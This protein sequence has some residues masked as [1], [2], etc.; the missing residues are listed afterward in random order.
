MEDLD[1]SFAHPP[2]REA[3]DI[4]TASE[5]YTR[6]FAGRVGARFLEI[7]RT[8][9][10]TM[11]SALPAGSTVCDVGG[12]H[13]QVAPALADRGFRVTVTGSEASCARG[14]PRGTSF[15]FAASSLY[16]L[17]FPDGAFD[18]ALSIRVIGHLE[19]WPAFVGEL[20]RIAKRSVVLDFAS[21]RSLNYFATS[22]F[23][24][25]RR[26][27]GDTRTFTV[28]DPS[29]LRDVFAA[30]GFRIA[31]ERPQYVLPM[32]VYRLLGSVRLLEAVE[33]PAARLGLTARFGSP[34]L[35][36]A[37]RLA[38]AGVAAAARQALPPE[39][40]AAVRRAASSSY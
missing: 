16:E 23:G 24:L 14:L 37:D 32:A 5:A 29:R 17:P 31:A 4:E 38:E 26:I 1:E 8:H 15:R 18:V 33:R 2:I 21:A 28:F 7:Q 6:R 34:L 35:V 9:V 11:L 36:R 39:E 40:P 3:P 10:L 19:R 27:E 25:K 22:F 30:R 20:C 12:G 13:G